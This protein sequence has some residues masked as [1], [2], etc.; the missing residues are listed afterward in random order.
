MDVLETTLSSQLGTFLSSTPE[1]DS[2]P[3]NKDLL[4]GGLKKESSSTDI[5][6]SEETN[7]ICPRLRMNSSKLPEK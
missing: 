6:S 4:E 3:P 1:T 7:P 2:A 5:V